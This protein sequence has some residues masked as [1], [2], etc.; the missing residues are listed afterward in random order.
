MADQVD[1]VGKGAEE[2]DVEVVAIWRDGEGR[3][4]GDGAV[5]GLG[6]AGEVGGDCGEVGA[7]HDAGNKGLEPEEWLQELHEGG[8]D[9]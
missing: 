1:A 3:G 5:P 4:R 2:A 7:R 8:R 6:C 9:R